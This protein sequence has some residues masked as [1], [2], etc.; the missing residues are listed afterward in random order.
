MREAL[1]REEVVEVLGFLNV[2]LQHI[3]DVF[4]HAAEA[5]LGR[6][7]LGYLVELIAE[8]DLVHGVL[9]GSPYYGTA[10]RGVCHQ[11]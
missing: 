8:L 4:V 11:E 7:A 5:R 3:G 2:K 9:L 10:F 6:A 1:G